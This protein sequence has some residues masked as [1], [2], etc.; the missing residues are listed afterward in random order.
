MC[1]SSITTPTGAAWVA[2]EET[3]LRGENN[4]D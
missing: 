1:D 4:T 2:D 3:L